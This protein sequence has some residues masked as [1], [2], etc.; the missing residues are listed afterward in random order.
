MGQGAFRLKLTDAYQRRCS[1][2]GERTLP[3]LEAAHIKPYSE[4]GPHLLSNGLV[5]RSDLHKLF[6]D[7]YLT[8]T[9]DYKVEVSLRIKQEFEN[10]KEYYKF[11]GQPLLYLPLQ[12]KDQPAKEFIDYHNNKFK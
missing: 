12:L 7:H 9:S 3:V 5:L 2:T 4:S 6:D 1:F 10:G 8:I 11:H